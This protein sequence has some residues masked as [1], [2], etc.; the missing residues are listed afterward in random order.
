MGHASG[1]S[2]APSK[3]ARERFEPPSTASVLLR[4]VGSPSRTARRPCAV[5]HLAQLARPCLFAADPL[6]GC[7]SAD[8]LKRKD[9]RDTVAFWAGWVGQ[10]NGLRG[11]MRARLARGWECAR[12]RNIAWHHGAEGGIAS[13]STGVIHGKATG[14]RRCIGEPTRST[15]LPS[16][17]MPS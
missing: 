14:D 10:P 12:T 7:G 1:P 13:A 4:L 3:S 6:C 8:W 16:S 11:R 2:P 5:R 9:P 15:F 17:S